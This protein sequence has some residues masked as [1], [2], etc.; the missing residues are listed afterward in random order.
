MV[1]VIIKTSVHQLHHTVEYDFY[2]PQMMVQGPLWGV[3]LHVPHP[4][5]TTTAGFQIWRLVTEYINHLYPKW[6][7]YIPSVSHC[8]TAL[9]V[10]HETVYGWCTMEL[11]WRIFTSVLWRSEKQGGKQADEHDDNN[12]NSNSNCFMTTSGHS[13]PS[14][15]FLK[16]FY[17]SQHTRSV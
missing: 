8:N 11:K 1:E 2:I 12:R 6:F 3:W 7:V 10:N 16:K 9:K 15:I 14:F 17:W 4:H 5:I 13:H